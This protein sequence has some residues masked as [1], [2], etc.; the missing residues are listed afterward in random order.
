MSEL[1][2]VSPGK[3]LIYS[4]SSGTEIL[5]KFKLENGEES[6]ISS[7]IVE[8]LGLDIDSLPVLINVDK[9][10]SVLYS[11]EK[12][13]SQFL[14]QLI[15]KSDINF[16]K[17]L[18]QNY[19]PL[20]KFRKLLAEVAK[21]DTVNMELSKKADSEYVNAALQYKVN[22]DQVY[23]IDELHRVLVQF[24]GARGVRNIAERDSLEYG[25][26]PYVW[27]LDASDDTD[28][29]VK[30]PALYK[31][32]RNHWIYL[33]TV[34]DFDSGGGSG[35]GSV[36]IDL[37]NYYTKQE[38]DSKFCTLEGLYGILARLGSVETTLEEVWQTVGHVNNTVTN[39]LQD[40]F[41]QEV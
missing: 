25:V 21:S 7:A 11:S 22:R 29:Q 17:N 31:W 14:K 38:A 1:T 32:D 30:S 13:I 26:Y 35:G 23:T 2:D 9:L 16:V 37:S 8:S 5:Y 3:A 10:V 41:S 34:N 19:V 18:A 33:G 39:I 28:P 15:Q 36:N 24:L 40:E 20:S 6:V 12:D 4:D 27:V